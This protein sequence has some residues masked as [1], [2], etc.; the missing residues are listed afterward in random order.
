MF[1]KQFEKSAEISHKN[2]TTQ[3]IL[4]NWNINQDVKHSY[5]DE[6]EKKNDQQLFG[7]MTQGT[8]QI[9]RMHQNSPT[10][11]NRTSENVTQQQIIPDSISQTEAIFTQYQ[12]AESLELEVTTETPKN[13]KKEK[14]FHGNM[15]INLHINESTESMT[16]EPNTFMTQMPVTQEGAFQS[17][18]DKFEDSDRELIAKKTQPKAPVQSNKSVANYL[19]EKLRNL[20]QM[21]EVGNPAVYGDP[22]SKE[23]VERENMW[24]YSEE[25]QKISSKV[26]NDTELN[27]KNNFLPIE[28]LNEQNDEKIKYPVCYMKLHKQKQ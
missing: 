13:Y 15:N 5:N 8:E 7:K 9:Q 6:I 18:Q 23:V 26:V 28:N 25:L 2:E 16:M 10:S 14:M 20:N 1:H 27:V 24:M 12:S 17:K 21:K 4:R 3:E 22:R 11:H 19:K